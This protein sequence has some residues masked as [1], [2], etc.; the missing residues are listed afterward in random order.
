MD[1]ERTLPISYIAEMACAMEMLS[2]KPG[3]VSPGRPFKYLNEMTFI[4]SASAI[5]DAFA[6]PGVTVGKLVERAVE[7]TKRLTDR[8][9]NLGIILLLAPLVRAARDVTAK[10][11]TKLAETPG[12][13]GEGIC[14]RELRESLSSVLAGLDGGDAS[15]IYAAIRSAS[16]EGLDRSEKY[17]VMDFDDEGAPPILEAMRFA[18]PRDSVAREYATGYEITFGLTAPK[19]AA[20]WNE[21]RDLRASIAQTFLY[22]MSEI[23]D[24]LIA[25][26][27]G[28]KASEDAAISAGLALDLGGCF[29]GEG[30][31]AVR[32]LR[33]M[34]EDPDNLMN[35][36]TTADLLAAGLFVFLASEL[37]RTPLSAILARWD[38]KKG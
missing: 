11:L 32:R 7:R 5:A 30:R 13:R 35:P 12:S 4:A 38:R 3:N 21:G 1:S 9:T 23:P 16:P 6:D 17:D 37:E 19:L 18:S 27:M 20:L 29:T 14:P 25:R 10:K 31:R 24:T 8:N 22:L 28:R 34:L 2:P 33:R 26:K 36:G 15:L